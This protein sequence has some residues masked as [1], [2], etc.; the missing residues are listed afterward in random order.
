MMTKFSMPLSSVLRSLCGLSLALG[1]WLVGSMPTRA[2]YGP[3]GM[4]HHLSN[5]IRTTI[6]DTR[7][8][9]PGPGSR[10]SGG[11][12]TGGGVRGCVDEMIAI[13]PV[14]SVIGQAQTL[15]PTVVWYVGGASSTP[16]E[17]V[18]SRVQADCSLETIASERIGESQPGF[19][20]YTLSAD[21]P[22]LQVG[23]TYRWEVRAFCD[24]TLQRVGRWFAAE[25]EIAA[26]TAAVQGLSADA[27]VVERARLYAAEG[28]WYDAIALVYAADTPEAE[29]LRRDLL[30]DLAD[31]DNDPSKA[32]AVQR[33]NRLRMLSESL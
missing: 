18:F 6:G 32:I 25:M 11:S 10:A 33:S 23:E 30:L 29:A 3:S 1:V 8:Y 15:R 26:P 16:L 31:L 22:E 5:R 4:T 28:F 7:A 21:Q 12:T 14:F 2:D 24:P 19:M 20:A 13:A 9:T 17:V 27:D